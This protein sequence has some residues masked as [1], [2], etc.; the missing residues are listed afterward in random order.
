MIQIWKP[1]HSA[2]VIRLDSV[3]AHGDGLPCRRIGTTANRLGDAS[4]RRV[5]I[6]RVLSAI[7]CTTANASKEAALFHWPCRHGLGPHGT[8]ARDL[9]GFQLHALQHH[10]RVLDRPVGILR[11]RPFLEVRGTGS[12]QVIEDLLPA[13]RGFPGIVLRVRDLVRTLGA[14]AGD[15]DPVRH[16]H[17]HQHRLRLLRQRRHLSESRFHRRRADHQPGRP[18][19]EVIARWEAVRQ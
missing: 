17:R 6:G 18:L 10:A 2:T 5:R 12:L 19:A 7:A 16:P 13:G 3:F 14:P 9:V 11:G 1:K 4:I 15:G 8:I